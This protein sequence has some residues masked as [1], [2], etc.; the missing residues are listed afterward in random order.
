MKRTL[1][2][3]AVAFGLVVASSANAYVFNVNLTVGSAGPDV[4]ALQDMLVAGGYLIMPAGVSKGNFGPLTQS[5]VAKWQAANGIAPAAGYFG[6]ISRAKASMTSGSTGS[7]STVPGCVAGAMFSSTTGQP[8]SSSTSSSSSLS[9]DE[10]DVKNMTVLASPSNEDISEGETVKVYG[11]EVEASD[12]SDLRLERLDVVFD[13]LHSTKTKR[14]SRIFDSAALYAGSQ[15]VATVSELDSSSAWSEVSKSNDTYRIR[16]TGVNSVIKA[17]TKVKFYVEVEA[18]GTLK[19]TDYQSGND[20]NV[21]VPAN[22]ARFIDA[23][24]IDVYA[25]NSALSS[26]SIDVENVE[27]AEITISESSDNPE[28]T[29]VVTD[30]DKTTDDVT[31]LVFEIESEDDDIALETMRVYA[32]STVQSVYALLSDLVLEIDGE[33]FSGTIASTTAMSTY[34]EF[35]IDGDVEISEDDMVEGLVIASFNKNATGTIQFA[36]SN[37]GFEAESLASGDDVSSSDVAG[38]VESENITLALVGVN[39]TL[40]NKSVAVTALDGATNDYS[41]ATFEVTISNNGKDTVF[42]PLT[43]AVG[44]AASSTVGI[45]FTSLS[46]AG[47]STV[48]VDQLTSLTETSNSVRLQKGQTAKVEV[49]VT[50]LPG[51]A[52]TTQRYE[53][54]TVRFSETAG[55]YGEVFTA[56]DT[57]AY[58]TSTV[59]LVN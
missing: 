33:E 52:M 6:P 54:A 5:A 22:G 16:F 35:D 24:G 3:L 59:T 38:S 1:L 8:C 43:A 2:S 56:P 37:A 13:G 23:K 39:V 31:V 36:V 17:G 30:E 46:Q 29:T 4:V 53:L 47:T 19:T 18:Q 45:S 34:Y 9:G 42:V 14:H 12:D 50:F 25:S 40:S 27:T 49:I 41:T 28:S 15:K 26:K 48:V 55:A 21:Y 11:F 20:F 44:S 10:G 58:R 7:T 57:S 51:A 32:T